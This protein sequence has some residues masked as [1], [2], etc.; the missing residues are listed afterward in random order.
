MVN[1]N[2]TGPQVKPMEGDIYTSA[3]SDKQASVEQQSRI[4]NMAKAGGGSIVVP[5]NSTAYNDK[6]SGDQSTQAL[7]N[8]INALKAGAAANAEFDSK[9]G[10]SRRRKKS[11]RSK[12]FK[13]SKK[14]KKAKG[15]G[16]KKRYYK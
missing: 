15:K 11:K 1:Y 16:S 2:I 12:K 9:V 3:L 10:G 13:R 5:S 8:Q 4:N 7:S 14:S 6:A